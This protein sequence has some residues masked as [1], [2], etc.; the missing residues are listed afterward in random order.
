MKIGIDEPNQDEVYVN[1]LE[2]MIQKIKENS[3]THPFTLIVSE[4]F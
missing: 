1:F 2:N 4:R 3:N